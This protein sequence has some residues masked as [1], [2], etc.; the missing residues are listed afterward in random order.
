MWWELQL[1]PTLFF[2]PAHTQLKCTCYGLCSYIK[3][4]VHLKI[5]IHLLGEPIYIWNPL[6]QKI[7]PFLDLAQCLAC[8]RES[9]SYS[10]PP[11]QGALVQ[12]TAY[13]AVQGSPG[14][15]PECRGKDIKSFLSP[16]LSGPGSLSFFSFSA[17]LRAS[18]TCCVLAPRP[19][20][21]HFESSNYWVALVP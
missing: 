11:R 16:V 15:W 4:F 2:V 19:I 3:W 20:L 7:V 6:W 14:S 21:G 8:R 18:C 10:C 5:K 12:D 17:H 13:A 1:N 9:S